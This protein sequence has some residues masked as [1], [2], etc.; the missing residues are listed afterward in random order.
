MVVLDTDVGS[1][2][3]AMKGRAH[4]ELAKWQTL[5]RGRT[6][7]IAFQTRAEVLAW[8]IIRDLGEPRR[9]SIIAQLDNTATVP[10]DEAVIQRYAQLTADARRRGDA[11]GAKE[12]TADRWVAATAARTP[13]RLLRPLHCEAA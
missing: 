2:L 12:H 3:F 7:A 4:P 6:V 1:H 13:R 10:A 5:L 8:V 11:L 9:T